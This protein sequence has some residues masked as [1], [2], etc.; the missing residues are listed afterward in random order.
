MPSS[1]GVKTP[2]SSGNVYFANEQTDRILV[3]YDRLV[4]A[5]LNASLLQQKKDATTSSNA[6][7]ANC[8]AEGVV[9]DDEEDGGGGFNCGACGTGFNTRSGLQTHAK[10]CRTTYDCAACRRTFQRATRTLQAFSA[11][12]NTHQRS[13]KGG[14]GATT[15]Q[16]KEPAFQCEHCEKRFTT[17]RSLELHLEKDVCSLKPV[18]QICD[19]EFTQARYYQQH[20]KTTPC[21]KA[22]EE[23]ER[24]QNGK[25]EGKGDDEGMDQ[26][27]TESLGDKAMESNTMVEEKLVSAVAHPPQPVILLQPQPPIFHQP[28]VTMM[29]AHQLTQP[30]TEVLTSGGEDF[31]PSSAGTTL[32]V[33]DDDLPQ[34]PQLYQ[35]VVVLEQQQRLMQEELMYRQ[36]PPPQGQLTKEQLE[37]AYRHQLQQEMYQQQQQQIMEQE[38][39]H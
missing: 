36:Q 16:R 22:M 21:G 8:I 4:Y 37:E 11:F 35:D 17:K 14:G 38:Q 10:S 15:T 19:K 32:T 7:T 27:T 26:E 30:K 1:S 24:K 31:T 13:C 29:A 39:Q 28:P 9:G 18:C 2:S 12:I 20:L 3:P 23:V 6:D 5:V 25:Q 33:P 34:V